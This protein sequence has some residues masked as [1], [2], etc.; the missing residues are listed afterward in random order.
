MCKCLATQVCVQTPGNIKVHVPMPGTLKLMCKLLATLK[1]MCKFLATLKLMCK[2]LATLKL[3]RKP[4]PSSACSC[5]QSVVSAAGAWML[6]CHKLYSITWGA[7]LVTRCLALDQTVAMASTWSYG[8]YIRLPLLLQDAKTNSWMWG[9]FL[10]S[11][12]TLF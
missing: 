6:L 3:M 8:T 10:K 1:L 11:Y 12:L 7:V 9:V 2:F 4:L 5:V